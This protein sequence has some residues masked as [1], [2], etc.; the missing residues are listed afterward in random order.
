MSKE[1][2]AVIELNK[3][4]SLTRE[5]HNTNYFKTINDFTEEYGKLEVS[6]IIKSIFG[7]EDEINLKIK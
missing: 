5:N 6:D 4:F 2:L 3:S 7:T 1:E